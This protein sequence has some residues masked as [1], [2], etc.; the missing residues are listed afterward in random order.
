MLRFGVT[1]KGITFVLSSGSLGQ[2]REKDRQDNNLLPDALLRDVLK[3]H[4]VIF[5]Y[6]L[7]YI[8]SPEHIK[9][10]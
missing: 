4:I 1:E 8:F 6:P 9:P 7:R 5:S 2:F 10:L 3:V